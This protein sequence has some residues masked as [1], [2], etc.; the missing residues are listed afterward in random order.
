MNYGF[1]GSFE[2]D[3]DLAVFESTFHEV[4]SKY[5][6]STSID[7]FYESGKKGIGFWMI[8]DP[9][10]TK[11]V[12][13]EYSVPIT[14]EYSFYFQKQPGLDWKNFKFVINGKEKITVQNRALNIV[15]SSVLNNLNRIGDLYVFDEV[16]KK[17]FEVK[18]KFKNQ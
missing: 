16:L 10:T 1:D 2:K 7:E 3:R 13:F 6:G 15:E 11:I 8:T 18:I 14:K 9:K 5:R 4:E 17:D 12:E